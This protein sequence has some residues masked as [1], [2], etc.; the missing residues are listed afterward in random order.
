MSVLT[1]LITLSLASALVASPGGASKGRLI[2][3]GNSKRFVSPTYA[4][5]ISV[6]PGWLAAVD[7]DTPMYINFRFPSDLRQLELPKGGAAIVMVAQDRLPNPGQ[8]GKTPAQ[9]EE[10]EA[11]SA[12]RG[13]VTKIAF[14]MPPESRAHHAVVVAYDTAPPPM[15]RQRCT[16]AFWEFEGRLFAIRLFYILDDPHGR[17]FEKVFLDTLRTLRPLDNTA[18]H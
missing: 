13:R 3:S 14:D 1:R 2:G 4:F 10:R 5:S 6:P 7:D 18:S 16:A 11:R 8:S 15:Q 12:E 9:W 17:A